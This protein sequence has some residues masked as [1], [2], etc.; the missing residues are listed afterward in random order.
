MTEQK[1]NELS[2]LLFVHCHLS[3][4]RV[5]KFDSVLVGNRVHRSTNQHA[6]WEDR[7]GAGSL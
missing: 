7:H 6:E 4:I 1:V 3:R 2:S 5:Q